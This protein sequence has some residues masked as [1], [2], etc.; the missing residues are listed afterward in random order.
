MQRP[1]SARSTQKKNPRRR[2]SQ[3]R[4]CACWHVLERGPMQKR[5]VYSGCPFVPAFAAMDQAPCPVAF[6]S[7]PACLTR[8]GF[9]EG[10]Y[11]ALPQGEADRRPRPRSRCSMLI[12][13]LDSLVSRWV[14]PSVAPVTRVAN[15]PGGTWRPARHGRDARNHRALK[16]A[17]WLFLLGRVGWRCWSHSGDRG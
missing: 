5:L 4:H 8:D 11:V 9:R 1:R 10:R 2:L 3:R 16:F 7:R 14:A 15:S 17:G 13:Q 12:G 6:A